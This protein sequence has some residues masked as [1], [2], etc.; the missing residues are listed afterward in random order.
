MPYLQDK[1]TE[2]IEVGQPLELFKEVEG[3]KVV[4][5]VLV[6]LDPIL[7]ILEVVVV[8]AVVGLD[9]SVG[10]W[11]KTKGIKKGFF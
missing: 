3:Q 1:E 10:L 6:S 11:N 2:K 7:G 9:I 8:T 5:S 4:P